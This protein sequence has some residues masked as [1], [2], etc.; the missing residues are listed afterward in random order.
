MDLMGCSN[1]ISGAVIVQ[2]E[3]DRHALFSDKWMRFRFNDLT[4]FILALTSLLSFGK[5]SQQLSPFSRH[6]YRTSESAIL[7]HVC[8]CSALLVRTCENT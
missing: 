8:L 2:T 1:S 7:L 3:T 6:S 4:P 5:S